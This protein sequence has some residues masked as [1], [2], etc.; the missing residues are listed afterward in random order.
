MAYCAGFGGAASQQAT[1]H[2]RRIYVGGLPPSAGEQ[3]IAVFFSNAL[4]AV[5][6][7]TAGPGAC[8]VNVYI[9]YEK[10]FA[11]VEFRTGAQPLHP[12]RPCFVCQGLL[13]GLHA[14]QACPTVCKHQGQGTNERQ[15]V[16][17]LQW[18]RLRMPWRW[19]ASCL[20][21]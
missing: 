10:K 1:R 6:G 2:A 12:L 5:G 13:Y 9:N 16:A 8:V 3:N 7:T 18:R 17:T 20:R 4:A 21:E 14:W 19:M 11:F 15:D